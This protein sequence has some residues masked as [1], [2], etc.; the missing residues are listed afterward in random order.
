MAWDVQ[1]LLLT[2]DFVG[3]KSSPPTS[4]LDGS[5][6]FRPSI[7]TVRT[8]TVPIEGLK[9][10]PSLPPFL[11]FQKGIS[12]KKHKRIRFRLMALPLSMMSGFAEHF[13]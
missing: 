13:L 10:N 1:P 8:V 4:R 6:L 5:R 7:G 12:E 2:S 3:R 9:V 11:P